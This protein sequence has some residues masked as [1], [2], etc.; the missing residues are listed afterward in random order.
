[1]FIKNLKNFSG[2][3]SLLSSFK[4]LPKE[5]IISLSGISNEDFEDFVRKKA[6]FQVKNG[7]YSIS[8]EAN[9]RN[10][11][12]RMAWA[13]NSIASNDS[14][15]MISSTEPLTVLFNVKQPNGISVVNCIIDLTDENLEKIKLIDYSPFKLVF[16]VTEN[17]YLGD[18][19]KAIDF[20]S[21]VG[22]IIMTPKFN[23]D[24][25]TYAEAPA[26]K[27]KRLV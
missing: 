17:E 10:R 21:P 4:A 19:V 24:K 20:K 7:L 26:V 15:F 2:V 5:L 23:G 1:M 18:I 3:F 13:I 6:L 22:L 27:S 16:F 8:R 9:T 25:K 11:F 12:L 14:E